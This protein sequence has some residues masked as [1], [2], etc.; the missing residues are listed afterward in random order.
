M[1]LDTLRT[2]VPHSN[3]TMRVEVD[4]LSLVMVLHAF[5]LECEKSMELTASS[6]PSCF[7]SS[8]R[9]NRYNGHVRVGVD[10]PSMRGETGLP[11]RSCRSAV[12]DSCLGSY[13][14]TVRRCC[15]VTSVDMLAAEVASTQTG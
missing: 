8:S 4:F 2:I 15:A 6:Q 12:V 5:R 7:L 13:F 14:L 11:L 9:E 1:S 3:I 10:V